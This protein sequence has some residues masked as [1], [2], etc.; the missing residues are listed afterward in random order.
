MRL[1]KQA[2]EGIARKAVDALIPFDEQAQT[3]NHEEIKRKAYALA[4]SLLPAKVKELWESK[5]EG[6]K[7]LRVDCDVRISFVDDRVLNN[8]WWNED[9][10]ISATIENAIPCKDGRIYIRFTPELAPRINEIKALR[11]YSRKQKADRNALQEK[12]MRAL[13][14]CTTTKQ[15]VEILPELSR[16]VPEEGNTLPVPV[17]VYEKLRT[18]LQTLAENQSEKREE[19][20]VEAFMEGGI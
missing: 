3:R 17:Q 15:V 20:S 13:N 1:T 19:D 2:R 12:I 16:F 9:A 5:G 14:S 10:V 7:Y 8:K 18:E 11:D 6:G 4:Y